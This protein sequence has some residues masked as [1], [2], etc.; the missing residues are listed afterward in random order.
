MHYATVPNFG[1]KSI[2]ILKQGVI[3]TVAFDALNKTIDG[4]AKL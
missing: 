2:N 1:D 3:A 4:T